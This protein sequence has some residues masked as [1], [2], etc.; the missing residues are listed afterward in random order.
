MNVLVTG[1]TGFIGSRLVERLLRDDRIERIVVLHR[2]ELPSRFHIGKF[3][4]LHGDLEQLSSRVADLPV[5]VVVHLAGFWKSEDPR[6]LGR[7]N[8]EGTQHVI[9]FCRR[10]AV[11]RLIFT[12]S[13]NVN[14]RHAGA[15]A[16]SKRAAEAAVRRSK[17]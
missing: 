10:N 17:L 4:P 1:A 6:I 13:I 14:L 16:L 15:Y 5:H 8:Y 2:A 7:I 12:S 9:E 3:V 11:P